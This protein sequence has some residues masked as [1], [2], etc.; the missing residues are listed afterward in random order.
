MRYVL[1]T[2][3]PG[4]DDDE[5]YT[6]EQW[7]DEMVLPLQ[8][9]RPPEGDRW[10][11]GTNWKT[12]EAG[13]RACMFR[14]GVHG[15]GIVATGVITRGAFPDS[16]WNPDKTGDAWY[17]NV[18][19]DRAFDLNRMITIDEL[20]R[21]VPAFAW[22]KVYSSGRIV[23]GTSAE[24]LATLLGQGPLPRKPRRKGGQRFGVAEHNHLVELEAMELVIAGYESDRYVVRDV[25]KENLGWDLEA[26][27]GGKISYIEVKGA[28]GP[29]PEFF[30]TPNEHRAAREQE[31]WVAVVITG[32]F[33]AEEAWY[34]FSGPEV[35]ATA[36][37]TQFRVT[38]SR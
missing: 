7:L 22:N 31:G 37:P 25:S 20:A 28:T 30:L 14:Q 10:S 15:R 29:L 34:E 9:G 16:H 27:R 3:N 1:L 6:P 19:W 26:R 4:P 8:E 33:G 24:H 21:E 2:W 11:I 38:P 23:D 36:R 13:D 5:Q 17:V 12:I 32:I 18:A 35:T